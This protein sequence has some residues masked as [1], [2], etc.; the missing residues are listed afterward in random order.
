[1][2]KVNET[3]ES[4]WAAPDYHVNDREWG[5]VRVAV[6]RRLCF[7]ITPLDAIMILPFDSLSFPISVPL[8]R[9]SGPR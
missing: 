1:M 7:L 3:E 2:D 8:R 9:S 6:E 5:G 4:I